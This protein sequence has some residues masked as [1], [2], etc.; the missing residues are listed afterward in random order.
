MLSHILFCNIAKLFPILKHCWCVPCLK[1]LLKKS[2]DSI[3][4]GT[5]GKKNTLKQL[6]ENM[7]KTRLGTFRI[8]FGNFWNFENF[9]ICWKIFD[10]STLHGTLG[11]KTTLKQLPENVFKH[12]WVLLGSTLG[13]FEILK[14]FWFFW[15]FSKTR[16][17]MEHWA[18]FFFSEKLPQN[19]FKTRLDTSRN[20]FGHFWNFEFFLIFFW[21]FFLSLYLIFYVLKTELIFLSSGIWTHKFRTRK[22]EM[23]L[24]MLTVAWMQKE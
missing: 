12:V 1:T 13:I 16:P 21:N 22:C 5:L 4:H 7:F 23:E 14:F 24:R 19:M 2:Q 11:K 18:K 20:N 15:T 3:L 9:L 17:T 6:P 8:D 10:D